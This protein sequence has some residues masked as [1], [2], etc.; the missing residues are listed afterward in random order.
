MCH[1]DYLA[2]DC[3]QIWNELCK[4]PSE[5]SFHKTLIMQVIVS[6][7][8]FNFDCNY[9]IRPLLDI[10]CHRGA[11]GTWVNHYLIK[12]SFQNKNRMRVLV[13]V[14]WGYESVKYGTRIFVKQ[15][16]FSLNNQDVGWPLIRAP[17]LRLIF[18][19]ITISCNFSGKHNLLG[20]FGRSNHPHVCIQISRHKNSR[21]DC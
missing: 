6:P 9:P 4:G 5:A 2:T 12:S 16:V 21:Y 14:W 20:V 18:S 8:G 13:F 17:F 15:W 7:F 1:C 3:I 19:E 11:V 10:C